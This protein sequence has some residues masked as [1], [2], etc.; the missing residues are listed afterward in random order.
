MRHRRLLLA[1]S[2]VIVP[3]VR[4]VTAVIRV[5]AVGCG[6]R[7]SPSSLLSHLSHVSAKAGML[8]RSL[9]YAVALLSLLSLPSQLSPLS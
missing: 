8:P 6:L 7:E 4:S 3:A 9:A 2:A 1:C 5:F